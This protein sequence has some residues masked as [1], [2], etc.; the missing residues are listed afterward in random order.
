MKRQSKAALAKRK[1]IKANLDDETLIQLI[2]MAG[3]SGAYEEPSGGWKITKDIERQVAKFES[4]LMKV[5]DAWVKKNPLKD[6]FNADTLMD[7]DGGYN[8]FM[9]LRGEGVGIWDGRWDEYFN[10]PKKDIKSL[11][12][13]LKQKLRKYADDTGG[14]SLNQA[15]DD[16]AY[17]Q[18]YG[19]DAD[20]M[21]SISAKTAKEI[22]LT[23]AKSGHRQLALRYGREVVAAKKRKKAKGSFKAA[24]PG[25]LGN[26]TKPSTKQSQKQAVDLLKQ[27]GILPEGEKASDY[28]VLT[29]D[30][31]KQIISTLLKRK[32][33]KLATWASRNLKVQAA[34][35]YVE[36]V[37]LQRDHDFDSF[38]GSGGRGQ[39]GFFDSDEKEMLK[40]L[41]EWDYG[42]NYGD[43]IDPM[44][45][46]GRDDYVYKKGP[47]IMTYNPGLGHA[48]LAVKAP[49]GASTQKKSLAARRRA[50]AK[51]GDKYWLVYSSHSVSDAFES[52]RGSGGK[53]EDGFFAS[54]PK[55]MV[56]YLSQWDM[57]ES[58]DGPYDYK[59]VTRD[60]YYDVYEAG[61]YLLT[62]SSAFGHAS[63]YVKATPEELEHGGYA[64]AKRR[65]VAQGTLYLYGGVRDVGERWKW[66]LQGP[67]K[68][69]DEGLKKARY[70]GRNLQAVVIRSPETIPP[71]EFVGTIAELIAHLKGAM[72]GGVGPSLR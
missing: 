15:I 49:L 31:K 68:T 9:T 19:D 10:D 29:A 34:K 52:F 44:Q 26:N 23:L 39:Q 65:V 69:V 50:T 24:V 25:N 41:Q 63:L 32:Q 40:F 60:R 56:K 16:A 55:E 30:V 36:V 12:K 62:Y 72:A 13:V 53:G 45:M 2:D 59:D 8:V 48:G 17:E 28:P 6:M 58:G 35:N 27:G 71:K 37:F 51:R 46:K 21:A 14:G 57:G 5:L 22:V 64:S 42:D 70:G 61:E 18:A 33:P 7:A 47:Y 11:E 38:S 4:D 43:V 3:E 1:L 20:A 67:V 66:F 54:S